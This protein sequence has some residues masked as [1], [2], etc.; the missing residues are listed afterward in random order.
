M[1]CF[2]INQHI[3]KTKQMQLQMFYLIGFEKKLYLL[4]IN[5]K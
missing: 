5:N 4:F 2:I 3:I 1:L